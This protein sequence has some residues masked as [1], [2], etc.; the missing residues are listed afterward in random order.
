MASLSR[1]G[2]AARLCDGARSARRA[3]SPRRWVALSWLPSAR[4]SAALDG[5][6]LLGPSAR[7]PHPWMALSRLSS[8]RSLRPWMAFSWRSSL[9]PPN[10]VG[11]RPGVY[12]RRPAADAVGGRLHR[13]RRVTLAFR[14]SSRRCGGGRC[15]TL[16]LADHRVAP[17][18]PCR[19]RVVKVVSDCAEHAQ[20]DDHCRRPVE[21][22]AS[23]CD[24]PASLGAAFI[25]AV[26]RR[27]RHMGRWRGD[28]AFDRVGTR[29]PG[30]AK[31][32][33][34]SGGACCVRLRKSVGDARRGRFRRRLSDARRGRVP[35]K[36]Q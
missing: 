13:R 35:Q 11:R 8:V 9:P 26:R 36:R 24:S 7:P 15:T 30:R 22:A 28:G 32:A 33:V 29:C 12:R 5:A 3:R 4:G 20:R 25:E 14:F 10:V 2:R 27:F 19:I 21:I 31:L 17:R 16:L 23:G 34:R 18:R 6:L 1:A